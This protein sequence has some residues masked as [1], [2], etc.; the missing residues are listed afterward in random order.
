MDCRVCSTPDEQKP[1]IFRGEA[2]CCDRHKK[3]MTLEIQPTETEWGMMDNDLRRAINKE[4]KTAIKRHR[5]GA[6]E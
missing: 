1:Q 3:I 4:L 5:D 6:P 2:W